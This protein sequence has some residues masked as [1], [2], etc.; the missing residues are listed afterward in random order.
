[1]RRARAADGRRPAVDYPP[2]RIVR[3]SGPAF[4][5]GVEAHLIEGGMVRIYGVAKTIADC[6]KYR[7]KIGLDVAVEALRDARRQRLYTNDELWRC[8]QVCRVAN[9]ML[10]YLETMT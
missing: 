8:A 1:M 10:P 2:L 9:I 3:F 5:E 4:T 7:N 6:S